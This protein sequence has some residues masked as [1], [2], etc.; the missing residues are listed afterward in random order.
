MRITQ[1][2]G[3]AISSVVQVASH[4]SGAVVPCSAIIQAGQMPERFVLQ[5]LRKL[6]TE[7]VL[8]SNSW[9]REAPCLPQM[10]KR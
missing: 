10:Q 9:R 2:V 8:A 1:S 3:Y 7:G 5:I 6:V 4:P